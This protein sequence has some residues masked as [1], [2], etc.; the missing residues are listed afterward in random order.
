MVAS[1]LEELK[2]EVQALKEKL[3]AFVINHC[4]PA[5]EE[6]DAHM[7]NRIG[8]ERWTLDAVPPVIEKLKAEAKKQGL[9]KLY[10]YF[11]FI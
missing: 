1:P 7:E 8:K 2:P 4:Q 10:L 9:W 5:E 6:Y 11:F 3:E